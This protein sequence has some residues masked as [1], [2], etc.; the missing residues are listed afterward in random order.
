MLIYANV[1]VYSNKK[2]I[3]GPYNISQKEK[4]S[5]DD[6]WWTNV[7]EIY[8]ILWIWKKGRIAEV[9]ENTVYAGSVIQPLLYKFNISW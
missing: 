1:V 4:A 9:F 8:A 7:R 6:I 2:T 5:C 3:E